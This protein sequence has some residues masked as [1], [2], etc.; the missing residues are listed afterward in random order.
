MP[1]KRIS[2]NVSEKPKR[3]RPTI[4]PPQFLAET[5]ALM[6][7]VKTYR[8]KQ[9]LV[10]Q[11]IATIALMDDSRFY[12]LTGGSSQDVMAG[13]GTP[14]RRTILQALG[15]IADAK[16]IKAVAR[17]ICNLKPTT[18]AAVTMIRRYRGVWGEAS[19]LSLTDQIIRCVNRY[20]VEHP[21]TT[22]DQVTTAFQNAIDIFDD[23]KCCQMA[24][25]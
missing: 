19:C 1:T 14:M 22:R 12:W 5:T 16:E 9:N 11:T 6:P 10:Y 20:L 25:Y 18:A 2:E 7:D 3:G 21:D 17:K 24:D 13:R 8:G 4:F 15:R 23:A